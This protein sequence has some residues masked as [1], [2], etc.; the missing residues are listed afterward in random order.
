MSSA[1][2]NPYAMSFPLGQ[3]S[4][5][6]PT[7]GGGQGALNV[8]AQ[9]RDGGRRTD[10][11]YTSQQ[12]PGGGIK[13]T[14]SA[15]S[16]VQ[17]TG[18]GANGGPSHP[19]TAYPASPP[20]AQ[21]SRRPNTGGS[22]QPSASP[23]HAFGATARDAPP[24]AHPSSN[25]NISRSQRPSTA[26]SAEPIQPTSA[27][28]PSATVP[29]AMVLSAAINP[30]PHPSSTSYSAHPPPLSI[31][32]ADSPTDPGL[33][34]PAIVVTDRS[35]E[36]PGTL[37]VALVNTRLHEQISMLE[38]LGHRIEQDKDGKM[39]VGRRVERRSI[40]TQVGAPGLTTLIAPRRASSAGETATQKEQTPAAAPAAV[41]SGAVGR[42]MPATSTAPGPASVRM[43]SASS[44]SGS[45][46][47]DS[48]PEFFTPTGSSD[49]TFIGSNSDDSLLDPTASVPTASSSSASTPLTS[50]TFSSAS[51][52]PTTPS[53]SNVATPRA[54]TRSNLPATAPTNFPAVSRKKTSGRPSTSPELATR[55]VFG[56]DAHA[57]L[58]TQE[59]KDR[60]RRI[61]YLEEKVRREVERR[62]EAEGAV[63]R[64][65][66]SSVEQQ[67]KWEDM[68]GWALD[69]S[70]PR[71][72][73]SPKASS[74]THSTGFDLISSTP[75]GDGT[76]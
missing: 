74:L 10:G 5:G 54:T 28:A 16:D 44:G 56:G 25:Q 24:A 27:K 67:S 14:D 68:A 58:P 41:V 18:S 66:R 4:T 48:S 53:T 6:F 19:P 20:R 57:L 15:P 59:E 22:E 30:P 73:L 43:G 13:R 75:A 1:G 52:T 55:G 62:K 50:T 34:P 40:A 71:P 3:T 26:P 35:P 39:L 42:K 72:S 29:P 60:E 23:P 61:T 37:D 17:G 46:G 31:A 2:P 9:A 32:R 21:V 63:K 69:V 76:L 33:T 38:L 36:L 64:L 70:Q 47:L 11:G 51:T 49:G 8:L 7:P 12:R 65:D 45:G